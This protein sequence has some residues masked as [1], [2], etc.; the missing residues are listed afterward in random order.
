MYV[1]D[2]KNVKLE[3]KLEWSKAKRVFLV[4]RLHWPFN[5]C[6]INYLCYIHSGNMLY[7]VASSVATVTVY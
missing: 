3:L 4:D 7:V 6:I 2:L 5:T 1:K